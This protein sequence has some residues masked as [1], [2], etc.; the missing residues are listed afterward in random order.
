MVCVV[1]GCP[2]KSVKSGVGWRGGAHISWLEW[3]MEFPGGLRRR[4]R[5]ASHS[6]IPSLCLLDASSIYPIVTIKSGSTYCQILHDGQNQTEPNPKH[7]KLIMN[8]GYEDLKR[9][10]KQKMG[11]SPPSKKLS[12]I[13]HS[14]PPLELH[15]LSQTV[16]R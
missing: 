6:G 5:E 14:A 11:P 7:S 3:I 15:G 8:H 16:G 2:V 9:Q 10:N 1:L 4:E 13:H 12:Y